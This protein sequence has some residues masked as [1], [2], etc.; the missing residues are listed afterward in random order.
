MSHLVVFGG[1]LIIGAS[2]TLI[3]MYVYL[4]RRLGLA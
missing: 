1:G 3:G 2:L 4:D